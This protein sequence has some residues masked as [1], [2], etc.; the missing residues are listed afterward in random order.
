MGAIWETA[1]FVLRALGTRN[2]QNATFATVSQILVLLA[3]LCK[4][5]DVYFASITC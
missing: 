3:P 5:H 1:S 4:F 2:Q